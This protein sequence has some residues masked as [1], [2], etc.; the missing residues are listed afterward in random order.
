MGWRSAWGGSPWASSIAV[1]PRDQMSAYE[2]GRGGG[3]RGEGG[4]GGKAGERGGR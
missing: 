2:G 1:M 3:G 4:R